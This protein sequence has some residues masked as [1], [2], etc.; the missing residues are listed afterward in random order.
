MQRNGDLG[1]YVAARLVLLGDERP[2][3]RPTGQNPNLRTNFY[4]LQATTRE[5]TPPEHLVSFS[6]P[7]MQLLLGPFQA[8]LIAFS[9]RGEEDGGSSD[10]GLR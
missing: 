2:W 3:E 8:Y 4:P 5:P 10:L 9:F 6:T 7:C 1:S